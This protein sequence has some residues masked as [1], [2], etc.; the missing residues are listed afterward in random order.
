MTRLDVLSAGR[1]YCDLVFTGLDS[2]PTPGREVFAER[3][4]ISPGGGAHITARFAGALGLRAGVWGVLPAAP[5]DAC[6]TDDLTRAGVAAHLAPADPGEDPQL[7]MAIVTDGDRAFVTRRTGRA[8]PYGPLPPARHLHLGELTTALEHPD[9]IAAARAAGM[10]VSLDC[11]WDEAALACPDV[12]AIV[13]AVDLF[14]PN[15]AEAERLVAAGAV[16]APRDALVVKC[17]AEGARARPA[18][19]GEV[20]VGADRVAAIDTTGAGDA[21]NAGFLAGWLDGAPLQTCLALGNASG[22][23]AVG[24]VGGAGILP[25][26]AHLRKA[27]SREA[28]R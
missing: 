5:F 15:Q 6:V 20:Q 10:T 7:T 26:L 18:V 13:A 19:G 25:S 23:V 8:L 12:P 11:G 3:L 1:I 24:R 9:L 21:F 17:G 16:L 2:P 14:L 28:A 27:P 4:T 22:A